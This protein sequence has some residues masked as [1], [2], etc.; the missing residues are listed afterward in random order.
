MMNMQ[1]HRLIKADG[2]ADFKVFNARAAQRASAQ[3]MV[4][5]I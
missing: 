4:T 2:L 3:L 5:H 1:L